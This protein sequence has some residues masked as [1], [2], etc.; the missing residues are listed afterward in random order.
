MTGP[1]TVDLPVPS[2]EFLWT[3]SF[4]TIPLTTG[5]FLSYPVYV[6]LSPWT[7]QRPRPVLSGHT[8]FV[9]LTRRSIRVYLLPPLNPSSVW[10]QE[11]SVPFFKSQTRLM[12]TFDKLSKFRSLIILDRQYFSYLTSPRSHLRLLYPTWNTNPL[13]ITIKPGLV[14]AFF[15]FFLLLP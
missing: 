6:S 13:C 14:T 5:P 12:L 11:L 10:S 8:P 3:Y 1:S 15:I 9:S 7:I 2:G 4:S